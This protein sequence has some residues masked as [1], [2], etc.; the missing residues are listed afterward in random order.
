MREEWLL[1]AILT[2]AVVVLPFSL[3]YVI[4]RR[5]SGVT[6][7]GLASVLL[8]ILL[9]VAGWIRLTGLEDLGYGPQFAAALFLVYVALPVFLSAVAA[10]GIGQW[11]RRRDRMRGMKQIL[12]DDVS[13]FR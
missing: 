10:L 13:R 12:R 2:L 5:V 4:G 8:I 7:A 9:A 3:V 1:I 6:A 11:F